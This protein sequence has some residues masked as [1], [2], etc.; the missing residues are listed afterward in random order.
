MIY[1]VRVA[2]EAEDAIVDYINYIGA[3]Q[4]APQAALHMLE[5]IETAI[6][7]LSS[8]PNRCAIAPENAYTSL[9]VRML[10]VKSCMLL[11]TVD[12]EAR[13]VSILGFRHGRQQPLERLPDD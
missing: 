11:F 3:E 4:Q 13:Q 1:S 7:S 8:F 5:R 2:D 12:E 10:I 6:A 9:E